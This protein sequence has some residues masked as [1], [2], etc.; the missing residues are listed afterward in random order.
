MLSNKNHIRSFF[1]KSAKICKEVA[2]I[3]LI[4]CESQSKGKTIST[5]LNNQRINQNEKLIQPQNQH[6]VGNNTNNTNS[7]KDDNNE[8]RQSRIKKQN[9]R[10]GILSAVTIIS[11]GAMSITSTSAFAIPGVAETVL[12]TTFG[13]AKDEVMKLA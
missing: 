2:R 12:S 4:Y 13:Y 10:G 7:T 5:H 1:S 9:H 11:V 3:D 6:E 8:K